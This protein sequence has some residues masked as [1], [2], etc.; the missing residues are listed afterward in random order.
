MLTILRRRVAP[1]ATAR[2]PP[3]SVPAARSRLWAIA[4]HSAQAR[5]GAESPGG[6]V[7]EGSVDEVGEDGFD[8]RVAAVGDVG[9]GS[10]F[11]GVGEERV[12]SPHREQRVGV[13]GV[14]DA[15][16]DQPGGHRSGRGESGVGN[17]G[18]L[19]IRDPLAGVGVAH[20]AGVAHRDPRVVLDGLDRFVDCGVLGQDQRELG[21]GAAAGPDHRAGAIGRIAAHQDGAGGPG[22]A[23]GGDHLGD[24]ACRALARAGPPG[25]QPHPGDHRGGGIGADGGRQR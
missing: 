8:D 14:F 23:G 12:I 16:H 20:R 3:A 11:G 7:R 24:H 17:F 13:A 15:A 6:H 5:V 10:R 2:W 21:A 1:R 18:D 22:A 9:V 25:P 19:G 4:A